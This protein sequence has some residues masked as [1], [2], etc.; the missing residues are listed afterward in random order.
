MSN[1]IFEGN[2]SPAEGGAVLLGASNAFLE[3]NQYL[4]NCSDL[5]GGA[6]AIVIGLIGFDVGSYYEGFTS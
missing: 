3:D 1:T 2:Y 6:I 4:N 5:F